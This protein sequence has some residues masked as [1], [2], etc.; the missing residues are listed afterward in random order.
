MINLK[1]TKVIY[2]QITALT[3]KEAS[4]DELVI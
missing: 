3:K 4:D 1:K 2:I